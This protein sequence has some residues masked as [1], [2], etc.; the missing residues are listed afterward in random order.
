MSG[1]R[2]KGLKLSEELCLVRLRRTAPAGR[3]VPAFCSLLAGSRL[4]TPFL[5]TEYRA[6]SVVAACC[7][8]AADRAQLERLVAVDPELSGAVTFTRGVGLLTL[9]PH[10]SNLEMFGRSLRVLVKAG[11]SV[12]GLASSIG[13]LT[14]VLNYDGLDRAAKALQACFE[15]AGNH[16][17]FRAEFV[18]EQGTVTRP[19]KPE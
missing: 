18:V 5:T 8:A 19:G 10:Q 3:M 6:G 12:Y 4:N 2:I 9:Y 15:L 7:V 1:M 11:L 17:P 14:Y 16:A 13:A